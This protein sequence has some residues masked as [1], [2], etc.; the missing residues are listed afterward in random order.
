MNPRL[1]LLCQRSALA[2]L[3]NVA[4]VASLFWRADEYEREWV[5]EF[6]R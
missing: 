4:V 3:L 6:S 5:V 2:L 1:R